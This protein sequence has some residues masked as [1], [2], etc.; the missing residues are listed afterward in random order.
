MELGRFHIQYEPRT[1]IKG[2]ILADFIAEFTE[3]STSILE[4]ASAET[5]A[6]T[7]TPLAPTGGEGDGIDF[8]EPTK[9]S[10]DNQVV[11]DKGNQS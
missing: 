3:D 11:E 7:G 1:A 2:Q 8:A 5:I 10:A 4:E 6:P 9:Q